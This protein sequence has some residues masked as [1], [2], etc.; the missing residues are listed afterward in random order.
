MGYLGILVSPEQLPYPKTQNVPID[1]LP[2][3]DPAW[4]NIST[5]G[6]PEENPEETVRESLP[7][8]RSIEK[9]L[10]ESGEVETY[11]VELESDHNDPGLDLCSK[12]VDEFPTQEAETKVDWEVEN[13]SKDNPA[14]N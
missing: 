5:W 3:V 7:D 10:L 1:L 4:E 6:F 12:Y 13:R 8:C 11:F 2:V 14:Q 9:S